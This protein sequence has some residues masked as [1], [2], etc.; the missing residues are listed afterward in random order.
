M[1]KGLL[2]QQ[3]SKYI[4]V[5]YFHLQPDYVT[6]PLGFLL[7]KYDTTSL[8]REAT[9]NNKT[10]TTKLETYMLY[11]HLH[12]LAVE[13]E[14]NFVRNGIHLVYNNLKRVQKSP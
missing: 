1:S 6:Y 14:M 11:D 9:M 5:N 3:L 4:R 8:R 13:A 12:P 10:I 2:K 7:Y